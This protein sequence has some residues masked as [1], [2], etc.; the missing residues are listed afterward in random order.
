MANLSVS[1]AWEETKNVIARDGRLLIAVAL[2]FVA[3]PV[4]IGNFL[5]P[6][7][8]SVQTLKMGPWVAYSLIVLL[9][10]AFSVIALSA[11]AIG[12]GLSVGEAIRR[13][14]ERLIPFCLV[15][16][17]I[18]IS[19]SIFA[20]LLASAGSAEPTPMMAAGLLLLLL[21]LFSPLVARFG[22]LGAVASV[23]SGG[24]L[25]LIGRSWRL[26][27]GSVLRLWAVFLVLCFAWF[28]VEAALSVTF[29]TVITLLAGPPQAGSISKLLLAALMGLLRAAE[30]LLCVVIFARMYMQ[31]TGGGEAQASVPSSGI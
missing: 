27:K 19:L 26:T 6:E 4:T 15:V 7:M 24:P 31:L 8:T 1:A 18:L 10:A 11:L 30:I 12:G 29:G 23:E 22:I 25:R 16:L 17:A 21:L 5:A 13:G 3:V 14:F 28:I 20:A 9:F 2:A